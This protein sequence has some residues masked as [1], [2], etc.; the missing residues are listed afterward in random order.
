MVLREK[1]PEASLKACPHC[2]R[3]V[4]Q[5]VAENS[6]CRRKVQSHFSATMWTGLKAK[7]SE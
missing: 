3:K 5:F 6:D 2:H 1:I 4:P 7:H